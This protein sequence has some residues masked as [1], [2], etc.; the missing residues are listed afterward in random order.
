MSTPIWVLLAFAGWTLLT[1]GTTHGF[2]RWPRVLSGRSQLREFADYRVAG[3]HGWYVRGMRAHA[4]CDR[5]DGGELSR[6][7]FGR[8]RLHCTGRLRSAGRL[9]GTP[10]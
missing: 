7:R 2:Y 1:L 4:F 5:E 9:H 10:S 3:E 8:E 6:R